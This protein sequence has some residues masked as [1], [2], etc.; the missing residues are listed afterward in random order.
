MVFWIGKTAGFNL[1]ENIEAFQEQVVFKGKSLTKNIIT[2][3]K[4]AMAIVYKWNP[5]DSL[6]DVRHRQL[7]TFVPMRN[8]SS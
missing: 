7:Q 5:S 4:K 2:V 3:G 1:I 6:D 8:G